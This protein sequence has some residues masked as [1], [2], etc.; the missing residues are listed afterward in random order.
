MTWTI[1]PHGNGFALYSGRD[2]NRHGMNLVYLSE[3]DSNW[4]AT[5]RLIEAAPDML[6]LL[7]AIEQRL[8]SIAS[9]T[10]LAQTVREVIAKASEP[11]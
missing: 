3:P 6:S 4:E 7:R 11:Q 5:K 9:V 1:Q 2:S 8:D 10:P